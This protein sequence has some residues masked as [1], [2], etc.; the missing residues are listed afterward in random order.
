MTT[1]AT[2]DRLGLAPLA[3]VSVSTLGVVVP[4]CNEETDVE[5]NVRRLHA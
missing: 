2:P 5:P 3:E 1:T 4:V